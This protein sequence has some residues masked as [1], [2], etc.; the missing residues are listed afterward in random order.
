MVTSLKLG[1]RWAGILLAL[2]LLGPVGAWA[3]SSLPQEA[4][5]SPRCLGPGGMEQLEATQPTGPSSSSEQSSGEQS[6]RQRSDSNAEADSYGI[7]KSPS[8]QLSRESSDST[9][10]NEGRDAH[11]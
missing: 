2:P 7:T 1:I 9:S 6:S 3:E 4:P 11:N 8:G 10:S 5:E